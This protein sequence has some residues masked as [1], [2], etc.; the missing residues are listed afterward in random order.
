MLSTGLRASVKE[1]TIDGLP[2][3]IGGDV[4]VSVDGQEVKKF[5]DLLSYLVQ[6]TAVGQEVT[7]GILRDG[8]PMEVKVTLGARPTGE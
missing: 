7:L 5:D 2:A 8:K 3:K 6:H 4:I 1:T